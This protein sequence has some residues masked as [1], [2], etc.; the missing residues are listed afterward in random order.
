MDAW[1][2][3]RG[4]KTLPVRMDRHSSNAQT[5]AEALV[6]HPKLDRVYYPGLPD[7]P[8]HELAARQMKS[9][10][11]MISVA[12]ADGPIARKFA[13]S[14]QLFQ[15]AES[16]GG[17]ESLMC[18]PAEMTHASVRG[19]LLEVPENVVRLSVGI[20]GVDDLLDDLL[21]TLDRL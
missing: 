5:I 3:I 17:V 4:I 1:L 21:G 15:L 13:E 10:G 14:T 9:F 11:G 20:E 18:Y 6:G 8:G 16:L 7:H 2:T 12:L 19:T